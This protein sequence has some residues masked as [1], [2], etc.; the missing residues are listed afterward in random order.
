MNNGL[1]NRQ[2][3]KAGDKVRVLKKDDGDSDVWRT[4]YYGI[5]LEVLGGGFL[6]IWD[7]QRTDSNTGIPSESSE[8]LPVDCKMLRVIKD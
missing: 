8:V 2:T 4:S 1:I 5:V 7:N 6:R 3:F